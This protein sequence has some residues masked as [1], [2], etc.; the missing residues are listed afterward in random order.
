MLRFS[1]CAL[2]DPPHPE[3]HTRLPLP[4]AAAHVCAGPALQV[5]VLA[6]LGA[7]VSLGARSGA[8]S[9]SW[10]HLSPPC[11]CSQW[12][13]RQWVEE[14]FPSVSLGDPTLDM[15]L[16]QFGL[17]VGSSQAGRGR[18]QGVTLAHRDDPPDPPPSCPAG[19]KP[20]P[21]PRLQQHPDPGPPLGTE[22]AVSLGG[23]RPALGAP[24]GC[25]GHQGHAG[26]AGPAGPASDQGGKAQA[27]PPEGLGSRQQANF[28]SPQQQQQ[29]PDP[30]AEKVAVI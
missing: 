1:P 29:L 11:C 13:R 20:A 26:P 8:G 28:P 9:A 25:G 5:L 10:P 12:W 17:Q 27:S 4:Q 21:G 3:P 22:T 30:P 18:W 24:R 15:L 19:Q 16:R 23:P 6:S 14:F 2:S 7:R